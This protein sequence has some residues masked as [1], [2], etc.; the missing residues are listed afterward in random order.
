MLTLPVYEKQV[1]GKT[2]PKRQSVAIGGPWDDVTWLSHYHK[3]LIDLSGGA[4]SSTES[5]R[6]E[7]KKNKS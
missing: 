5:Q 2:S 3:D 7:K 6:V 4:L 1:F